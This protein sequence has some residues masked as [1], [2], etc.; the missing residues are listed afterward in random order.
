MLIETP[1]EY[2]G[3]GKW[4]RV[5]KKEPTIS[6]HA[7]LTYQSQVLKSIPKKLVKILNYLFM[8]L[9]IVE[10][11]IMAKDHTQNV[12]WWGTDWIKGDI[13]NEVSGTI[14]RTGEITRSTHEWLNVKSAE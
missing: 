12:H 14:R 4:G 1:T 13:H 3:S 9:F 10:L 8:E 5:D 6:T 7:L 11:F 2:T